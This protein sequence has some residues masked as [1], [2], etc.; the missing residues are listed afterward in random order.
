MRR[1]HFVLIKMVLSMNLICSEL[2]A[3]FVKMF[4]KVVSAFTIV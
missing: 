2:V 3:L 1:V 4:A